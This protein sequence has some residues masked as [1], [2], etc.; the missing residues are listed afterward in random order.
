MHILAD[1]RAA[2]G[3][4]LWR[5]EEEL[6]NT[7]GHGV[8]DGR[9]APHAF[10]AGAGLK[11]AFGVE[12]LGSAGESDRAAKIGN[13][14]IIGDAQGGFVEGELASE[15]DALLEDEANVDAQGLKVLVQRDYPGL[16]R[17][18]P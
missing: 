9:E 17:K 2:F 16:E 1:D 15:A 6:V 18:E 3:R 10:R 13:G 5:V 4:A 14:Q 7:A 8:H 11:L 12:P